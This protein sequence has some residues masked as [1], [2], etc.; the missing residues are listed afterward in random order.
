MTYSHFIR[1]TL[2]IKDENIRF[3]DQ[4]SE[5]RINDQNHL[6]LYGKLTYT[7]K[8]CEKCGSVN[9]STDDIVKNGTK[10]STIKLTHINFKPVQL[11]LKKQRF[12]CKH[13]E[14]T[15]SA[16]TNLVDRDCYISNIIKSTISMELAETQSMSL[17]GKH[18]NVSS[19]TVIRQLRKYGDSLR[20]NYQYLPQHISMDEFKSVKNVSGAMSLMFIDARKHEVIDIVENRQQSYL[21]DYFLRYSLKARLQ[22]KTVTMDM[23]SPYIQ[24]VRDCFPN[25]KM[26]IDRFHIVQLLNRA[27]NQIRIQEMKKIRYTRPTDYTKLKKQWKLVLKNESDLNY[28]DFFTHRLY[29]GVV[30]EYVMLEYLLSISPRLEKAYRIVRQLKWALANRRFDYFVTILK[31]SK[32]EPYPNKIRTS[33]NTLEKYIDPIKNAFIYTLSNGPIEGMNNKVKNIKRSGYG[34]RS[35]INLKNRILISFN[36][37]RPQREPKPLFYTNVRVQKPKHSITLPIRNGSGSSVVA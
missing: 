14:S 31:E 30:S 28:N 17:I 32:K 26:I 22:V 35:F 9:E 34:Y 18:L 1:K 11:K 3:K 5:E 36:L 25:A 7:P 16:H 24:V 8:A 4:V 21:R 15:F 13:C 37:L 2:E 27:L 6:V 19:N 33:L 23:Y 12:L 20:N 10:T 29:D